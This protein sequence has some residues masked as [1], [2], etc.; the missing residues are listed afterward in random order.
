MAASAWDACPRCL[1]KE[2]IS[3]PLTFELGWRGQAK[4]G[5]MRGE[6]EKRSAR[7]LEG[8]PSDAGA[9]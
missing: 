4:R 1:A 6:E 5:G 3:V 2:K 7:R 9:G 8:S